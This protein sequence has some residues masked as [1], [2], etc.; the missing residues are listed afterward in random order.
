MTM[1]D[2]Y[3][4]LELA[5]LIFILYSN[6]TTKDTLFEKRRGSREGEQ[7]INCLKEKDLINGGRRDDEAERGFLSLHR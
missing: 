3:C 2:L 4:K 5:L 1:Q 6:K 7:T